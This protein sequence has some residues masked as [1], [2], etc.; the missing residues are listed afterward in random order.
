[1]TVN[2]IIIR[3]A[4][5]ADADAIRHI[6]GR[7]AKEGV[8]LERSTEDIIENIRNFLVAEENGQVIGSCA[9]SFFTVHLA[10]IR[11]LAVID[12]FTRRGVGRK[13]VGKAEEVLSEEGVRTAFVLTLNPDFFLSLGYHAVDKERFPQKIWRDCTYCPKLMACDE[14]AMIKDLEGATVDSPLSA[15]GRNKKSEP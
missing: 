9:L 14:I 10:E 8:M 15:V 6:S 5:L 2:E 13:L 1:M 3:T 12:T 11:T 7:Y 4:R